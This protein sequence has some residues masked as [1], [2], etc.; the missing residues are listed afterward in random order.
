MIERI[1]HDTRRFARRPGFEGT[2]EQEMPWEVDPVDAHARPTRNLHVHDAEAYR[3]ADAPVEHLVQEAVT[4]VG[5]GVGVAA[6]ADF[7]EEVTV[8]SLERRPPARLTLTTPGPLDPRRAV[9]PISSRRARYG[10]GV[11]ARVV[12]PGNDESRFGEAVGRL[13][14]ARERTDEV[15]GHH[16]GPGPDYRPVAPRGAT[17]A[18]SRSS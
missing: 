12:E 9:T 10:V 16:V 7:V 4:R 17:E 2:A 3:N 1:E 5:R 18:Q 6:E 11:E 13:D 14:R 8:E 15:G